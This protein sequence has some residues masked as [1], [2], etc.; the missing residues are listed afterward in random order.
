MHLMIDSNQVRS[1]SEPGHG[2][3]VVVEAEVLG[4]VDREGERLLSQDARLVPWRPGDL[5]FE[6]L[7][8]FYENEN[9]SFSGNNAAEDP[10]SAKGGTRSARFICIH[11]RQMW[12]AR[13]W[14]GTRVF[15]FVFLYL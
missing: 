6:D 9:I 8:I 14:R 3:G 11:G 4:Q 12:V 13:G 15:V 1:G 2:V 7:E 10:D 5:I